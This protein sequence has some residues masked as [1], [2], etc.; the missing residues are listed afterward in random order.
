MAGPYGKRTEGY[1]NF[2]MNMDLVS[3]LIQIY[4]DTYAGTL[5]TH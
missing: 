1:L 4:S 2:P 3:V 5:M